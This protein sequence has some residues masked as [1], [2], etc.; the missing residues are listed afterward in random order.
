MSQ[1]LTTKLTKSLTSG[2]TDHFSNMLAKCEF[3]DKYTP[4]VLGT[5]FPHF[6]RADICALSII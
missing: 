5:H 4:Q 6:P 2:F 1:K 3:L